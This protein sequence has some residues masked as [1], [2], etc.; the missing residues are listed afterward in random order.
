MLII[1]VILLKL[2]YFKPNF[3]VG[4]RKKNKEGLE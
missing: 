1:L 2:I 3:T 4:Q